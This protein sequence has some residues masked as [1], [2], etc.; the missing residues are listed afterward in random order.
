MCSQQISIVVLIL[1]HSDPHDDCGLFIGHFSTTKLYCLNRQILMRQAGRT[2]SFENGTTGWLEIFLATR[3]RR[4]KLFQNTS[5]PGLQ[6]ARVGLCSLSLFTH[7]C[8]HY[9]IFH[10]RTLILSI[11]LWFCAQ[12]WK[13]DF[14]VSHDVC[15]WE[16][17]KTFWNFLLILATFCDSCDRF[18]GSKQ[19]ILVY[20][21]HAILSFLKAYKNSKWN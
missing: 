13:C 20:K 15:N 6:R 10:T 19:V 14:P 17:P 18:T 12:K 3:C 4:V 11:H 9:R 1:K 2:P 8:F 16:H 7:W 5:V 21:I